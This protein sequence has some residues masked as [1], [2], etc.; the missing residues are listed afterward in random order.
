VIEMFR[1]HVYHCAE[2]GAVWVQEAEKCFAFPACMRHLSQQA[3]L[4]QA[5]HPLT[6]SEVKLLEESSQIVLIGVQIAV[7]AR[8]CLGYCPAPS[9]LQVPNRLI[10]GFKRH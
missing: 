7:N 8:A 10:D 6:N 3:V 9:R 1:V 2:E 4:T 5:K